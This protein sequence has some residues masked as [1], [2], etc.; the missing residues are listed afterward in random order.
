MSTGSA[1]S[2]DQP[3]LTLLQQDLRNIHSEIAVGKGFVVIAGI[4]L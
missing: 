2:M 4:S 1:V 3:G